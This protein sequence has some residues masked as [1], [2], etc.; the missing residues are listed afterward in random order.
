MPVEQKAKK[1]SI[2][3]RFIFYIYDGD[4]RLKMVVDL[5]KNYAT[6]VVTIHEG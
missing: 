4:K 3:R 5:M 2:E 1:K 6:V